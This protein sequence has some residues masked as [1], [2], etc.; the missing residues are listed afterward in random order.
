MADDR[1]LVLADDLTGALEVGA[2]FAGAGV[3]S[4]VRTG[5]RVTT[6]DLQNATGAFV[7]DTETRHA[8]AAEAARRVYE[9]ADAAHHLGFAYVYKKTDSTLRGNIG[10]ELAALIDAYAGS[11]LL[12]VPAYPQLGRTVRKGSLYVDGV[13]VAA[14]CFAGDPF[15]PVKESHIPT[16][17]AGQCRVPVRSGPVAYAMDSGP[18]CIVV[19]DGDTDG[20]VEA[21]AGAFV[22]S[23]IFQLAAGPA[24]FAAHFARVVRIPHGPP[25]SRPRVSNALVING[26][27]HPGSLAQ[28]E[29]AK[30][31]GFGSIDARLI[32][33]APWDGGW[34]VLEP[35]S[36]PCNPTLD[37]SK[38]LARSVC[39]LLARTPIDLLVVFGGDTTYAIVEAIGSPPL[40]PLGEVMEGIPMS[41]IA[42]RKLST[43][44]G[45]RDQDLYLVTKAG[46]FGPPN[47][48]ESIR[49]LLGER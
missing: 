16:L 17:L 26:S 2:K 20:D 13:L 36:E 14:T 7:V 15:N 48:L 29:Q 22:V 49:Q 10:A 32:P 41:R 27:L 3:R 1:I 25:P 34:V 4:M 35:G 18:P 42:A 46:S 47:V 23:P 40:D 28:V 39:Q 19:C 30:Q 21:A 5:P 11:S 37:F 33:D 8:G 44:V 9:L 12:Y 43:L 31:A 38:R 6:R 24:G 45:H